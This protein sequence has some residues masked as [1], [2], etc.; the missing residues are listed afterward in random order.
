M[1]LLVECAVVVLGGCADGVLWAGDVLL[2]MLVTSYSSTRPHIT[3]F[4]TCQDY[5][6]HA[7][8]WRGFRR[9]VT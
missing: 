1:V 7:L 3:F 6:A 4:E 9:L 2:N 8:R 5:M